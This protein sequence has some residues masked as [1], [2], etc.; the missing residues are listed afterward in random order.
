MIWKSILNFQGFPIVNPH[1]FTKYKWERERNSVQ[2]R[3]LL[4]HCPTA[5]F[6]SHESHFIWTHQCPVLG[7]VTTQDPP[8]GWGLWSPECSLCLSD[9]FTTQQSPVM[10]N[11]AWMS[12]AA[13]CFVHTSKV[14]I[15]PEVFKPP[16]LDL[17]LRPLTVTT[18][19]SSLHTFGRCPRVLALHMGVCHWCCTLPY[20]PSLSVKE[21]TTS[22]LRCQIF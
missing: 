2:R 8:T 7:T 15:F 4:P 21:A 19:P 22:L 1:E 13:N 9:P 20:A 3:H 12:L 10:Q 5:L 16:K 17:F 14:I 18:S 11:S 6:L